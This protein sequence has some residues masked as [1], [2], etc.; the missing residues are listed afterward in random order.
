MFETTHGYR[1]WPSKAGHM[2]IADMTDKHI[3]ACINKLSASYGRG[4]NYRQE[5][6]DVFKTELKEREYERNRIRVTIQPEHR[7]AASITLG[8]SRMPQHCG[9]CPFYEGTAYYD[10]DTFF[11]DGIVRYCPF[12]GDTFGC[13]VQRPA[14]CPLK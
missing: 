8:V 2:R 14:N 9:E 6:I 3:Q 10:E 1:I 11:G 13:L 5:W 7:S 4:Y 12:G